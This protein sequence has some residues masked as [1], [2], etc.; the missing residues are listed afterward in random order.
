MKYYDK[1]PDNFLMLRFVVSRFCNYRCPYCYL[2]NEKVTNKKDMFSHHS[3]KEWVTALEK[4]RHRHLEMYFTGGEPTLFDNFIEFLQHMVAL[5]YVHSVRIDSNLSRLDTFLKSVKSPKVKFLASF[6]P[7]HISL[8][9][10]MEK[11]ETLRDL[12]ML[13]MVNVVASRE[14]ITILNMSPH[15]LMRYFEE[16][17][18]FLNIAKDFH[19]GVRHGYDPIYREYIDKLQ[20]PLDNEYMNLKNLNKGMLCGPGKHY[21]TFN[22]HGNIYSCGG[23]LHGNIFQNTETL[24]EKLLPCVQETCPSIISYG[25]SSSN[26]FSPVDHL[27]DYE[28]R[29]REYRQ[30]LDHQ[31][32]DSMWQEIVSGDLMPK[33]PHTL[34]EMGDASGRPFSNVF[35]RVFKRAER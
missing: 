1:I 16:R 30:G 6:H 13:G 15:Q 29:N 20:H 28:S 25:F 21:I 10:F 27:Q 7:S 35:R 19:R 14:N 24:P 4:F 9:H 11:V 3:P 34:E 26:S 22:R 17:N 5:D 23:T 12:G 2:S 18:C 31:H 32:L 8:G 33:E